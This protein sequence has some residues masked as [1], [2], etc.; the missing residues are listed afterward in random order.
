MGGERNHHQIGV[1]IAMMHDRSRYSMAPR[2]PTMPGRSMYGGAVIQY[3]ALVAVLHLIY[4][5][6][7]GDDI[8]RREPTKC[9]F[10]CEAFLLGL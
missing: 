6:F 4:C 5:L 2:F 8:D 1:V 10:T 7:F 3:A 9:G